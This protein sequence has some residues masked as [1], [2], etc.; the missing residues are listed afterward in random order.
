MEHAVAEDALA[1]VRR[2]PAC[3]TL[4]EAVLFFKGFSSLVCHRAARYNWIGNGN[5]NGN[6]NSNTDKN[7]NNTNKTHNSSKTSSSSPKRFTA[8]WLQSQASAAFGVDI[9]P[10]ATIGAGVMFDHGTGIVI[11]ETARIGDGCTLLH[12]VTL[13]GTGKESGDRHP[14]VGNHVLVGA[15]SKILGNVT[16]GCGAKIG[17]G[18]VVLHPIPKGATAVGAPA[19]IIGWAKETKPGSVIDNQLSHVTRAPAKIIG[20]ANE[21]KPGSVIDNQLS[22][23]T[24]AT[25]NEHEHEHDDDEEEDDDDDLS[26]T[27]ENDDLSNTNENDDTSSTDENDNNNHDEQSVKR[28]D[29]DLPNNEP[30]KCN[31]QQTNIRTQT[32]LQTQTPIILH[33]KRQKSHSLNSNTFTYGVPA[34]SPVPKIMSPAMVYPNASYKN[35]CTNKDPQK[36][37]L[38]MSTFLY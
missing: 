9:H 21:T 28:M 27:D 30:N 3:D 7:N 19:K 29:D 16:I 14:K 26:N 15:G 13:G 11:G 33:K 22:H 1:C 37:R 35:T 36:K 18:S 31:K 4:L 6:G 2:D 8:L 24:L 10:A 23:V 25:A 17:A 12:G 5:N 32:E 20:W 38:I 34:S